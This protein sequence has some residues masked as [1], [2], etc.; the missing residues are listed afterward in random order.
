MFN[1][2]KTNQEIGKEIGWNGSSGCF[3]DPIV[4]WIPCLYR[5]REKRSWN[6]YQIPS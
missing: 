2:G 1:R 3:R 6:E 5:K 4:E